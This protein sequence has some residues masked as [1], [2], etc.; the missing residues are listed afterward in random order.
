ML[1]SLE[2]ASFRGCEIVLDTAFGT[3]GN[4]RSEFMSTYKKIINGRIIS[5]KGKGKT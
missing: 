1:K 4:E 3:T 2:I 5:L